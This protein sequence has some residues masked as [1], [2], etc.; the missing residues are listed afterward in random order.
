VEVC[1]DVEPAE[2]VLDLV[3]VCEGDEVPVCV[4]V[5]E[6]EAVLEE[7]AVCEGELEPV[8]VCDCVGVGVGSRHMLPKLLVQSMPMFKTTLHAGDSVAATTMR[9]AASAVHV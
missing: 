6:L 3:A 5:P 4:W 2:P 9:T 1:D 8:P 7:V